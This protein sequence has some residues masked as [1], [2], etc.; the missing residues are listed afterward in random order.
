MS[1]F[2]Q[3]FT[4]KVQYVSSSGGIRMLK[5]N[6]ISSIVWAVLVAFTLTACGG[7]SS[8]KTVDL[9]VTVPTAEIQKKSKN[10]KSVSV[11]K[12]KGTILKDGNEVEGQETSNGNYIVKVPEGSDVH[13]V[14]TVTDENGSE[15]NFECLV[16]DAKESEQSVDEDS[17]RVALLVLNEVVDSD[18]SIKDLLED[19][20]RDVV[21][22]MSEFLQS[23][24]N[25]DLINEIIEAS[26]SQES[27]EA[28]RERIES[29]VEKIKHL[30]RLLAL[31]D[32]RIEQFEN[33]TEVV[34][35]DVLDESDIEEHESESEEDEDEDEDDLINEFVVRHHGIKDIASG[36]GSSDHD[37][38]VSINENGSISVARGDDHS[39]SDELVD[40]GRVSGRFVSGRA[41][42][43]TIGVKRE[44]VVSNVDFSFASDNATLVALVGKLQVDEKIAITYAEAAG[45]KTVKS[46]FGEGLLTGT[47][48]ALTSTEVTLTLEN[49]SSIT[50]PLKKHKRH[51]DDE[52]EDEEDDD[53]ED[54]GE[55]DGHEDDDDEDDDDNDDDGSPDT[56]AP[57]ITSITSSIPDGVFGIGAKIPIT[58]TFSETITLIGTMTINLD[59]GGAV[60]I[61][62][63]TGTSASGVYTVAAGQNS[64]DLVATSVTVSI[65]ATDP[66]L[67]P[68]DLTLPDINIGTGKKSKTRGEGEDKDVVRIG[69]AETDDDDLLSDVEDNHSYNSAISVTIGETVIVHWKIVENVQVA[70]GVFSKKRNSDG[71]SDHD[72]EDGEDEDDEDK[73]EDEADDE[74]ED[75]EADSLEEGETDSVR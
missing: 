45:V 31:I 49:G 70:S 18:S 74:M 67:N 23:F 48:T 65:S 53:D 25:R 22:E 75:E 37:I 38:D 57:T 56:I 16:N 73:D 60:L 36:R 27:L 51:D 1:T 71:N 39:T 11:S 19:K 33:G 72:D 29:S 63:F 8:N 64:L 2:K 20:D 26:N 32:E 52:D 30:N 35:I 62:A 58:I 21:K 46:I 68:L 9:I 15:I 10:G 40:R 28:I 43:L 42:G 66:A 7:G 4:D 41:D 61:S 50:L 14:A 47:L 17:T 13:L 44:G 55:D 59:S 6:F 24:D 69:V 34:K 12:V 54:D 3:V 5:L